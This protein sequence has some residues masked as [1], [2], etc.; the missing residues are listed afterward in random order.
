ML[1]QICATFCRWV[2]Q[3]S[4]YL[5][6]DSYMTI[7][8]YTSIATYMVC[9]V[10]ENRNI[11]VWNL[12]SEAI[13]H[14]RHFPG[15]QVYFGDNSHYWTQYLDDNNAKGEEQGQVMVTIVCHDTHFPTQQPT[16]NPTEE[17]TEQPTQQP[18]LAPTELCTALKVTMVDPPES[19]NA[20]AMSFY[21]GIY[22][23]Q[24]SLVNGRDWWRSRSDQP[25]PY[26][27][28]NSTIY[29]NS[30]DEKW[31]I[32]SPEVWL[33]APNLDP[34]AQRSIKLHFHQLRTFCVHI[35]GTLS[36]GGGVRLGAAMPARSATP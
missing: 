23:K 13:D 3:D 20:I 6:S 31:V 24:S 21:N 7:L 15:L 26:D 11:R 1:F 18:T 16:E 14:D 9:T 28:T 30:N 25:H 4:T 22:T 12:V 36:E 29:W 10:V 2:I 19:E 34:S 35:Q 33:V 5:R 17:P 8:H 27:D 32:E